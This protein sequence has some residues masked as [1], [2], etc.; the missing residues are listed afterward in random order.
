[1]QV[2]Q[3]EDSSAGR[4]GCFQRL[5]VN[6]KSVL[7]LEVTIRNGDTTVELDLRLVDGITGVRVED[8]VARVHEG[9][10][11]LADNGLSTRLDRHAF[12]GVVE[13]VR[14]V[15]V[16]RQ[17]VPQRRDAGVRTVAGLAVPDRLEGRFND[18][19]RCRD[20]QVA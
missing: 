6:F 12:R 17:G 16:D 11:E 5:E 8:L 20:V 10:H 15:H 19:A 1:M 9:E 13:A 3:Y 18:V 4:D 7:P 14:G 2:V